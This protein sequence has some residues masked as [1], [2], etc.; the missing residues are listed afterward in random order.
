M[1]K[2]KGITTMLDRSLW[3]TPKEDYGTVSPVFSKTFVSEGEVESATLSVTSVGVYVATL[4][5]ERVGSFVLAPGWTTYPKRHQVQSYDVTSLIKKEN[6]LEIEVA[7]GWYLGRLAWGPRFYGDK[8]PSAIAELTIKYK[9]GSEKVVVTDTSWSV[10]RSKLK[11]CEIY[12]GELYD[13]SEE[14]APLEEV[15]EYDFPKDQLIA[16]EGEEV[17]EVMHIKPFAYIV[18]PKGERVIDFGQNLAGYISFKVKGNKG[19]TV[20]VRHF[21]ILDKD[22][23]VYTENYRSAKATLTYICE[24]GKEE[25]YKPT[26][27]FYGFRYIHLEEYPGDVSLDDF[28]AIVVHSDMKKTGK[29][30][31]SDPELNRLFRNIEWGQRGNFLDIPTDCP[32]R[33]ER[34]GWTGDAE[35]FCRTATYQFDTEKFFKKWFGDMRAEQ[36]ENGGIPHVIPYILGDKHCS[37]AWGDVATIAPWQVYLTYGHVEILRENYDCMKRW[38]EYIEGNSRDEYLW[39]GGIHFGDWCALDLGRETTD[40]ASNK[41]FIASVYYAN[42]VDIVVKAGRVLGYDVSEYEK[43][44]ENIVNTINARFPEYHTQTENA[45]ALYFNIARDR[46]KAAADLARLVIENGNKLNT[47]FLGTPYLLHALSSE[48]YVELAYTLLLQRE[49]PSWLFSVKQGA[50]T[51]W[52]HWDGIKEDGSVWSSSMNSYNHYA[53]GAVADWVYGVAAG[54]NTVE[55]APGFEKIVIAPHVDERLDWLSATIET[56]KGRVSSRWYK[57]EG[58][59]KYEIEVPSSA[60]VI[61]EGKEYSLEKGVYTF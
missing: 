31:C 33:D 39:T 20:R 47:G 52:E 54:I 24:G 40:S 61:I 50:T 51:I 49:Y 22:G 56:R 10:K 30:E 53:Y 41:D 35:I 5:G 13:A 16:Q 7:Y 38:I 43:K 1:L 58:K 2:T 25:S 34:L 59:Y 17:R 9:D 46:K 11:L 55:S 32:Q 37:C 4:S 14:E 36:W 23:N 42:S 26:H 29:L 8:K 19:D 6:T 48:G 21:E 44:Y 28:E 12:D 60:K 15:A 45:L 3:I 27:T 57:F 18:T